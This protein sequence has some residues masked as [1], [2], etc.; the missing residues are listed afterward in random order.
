MSDIEDKFN[1][2]YPR[3]LSILIHSLRDNEEDFTKASLKIALPLLAIPMMIELSMEAIFAVVDITFVSF[4]GTDAVAAVGITEALITVVYAVCMGLGVTVTAMV[5]RRIGANKPKEAA[6][7]TGQIIWIAGVISIIV[8]LIGYSFAADLLK[9]L[10]ASSNVISIGTNYTAIVFGGSASIMYL[11]LLNA[12][13]RGAGDASIAFKALALSNAMNIILD[14]CLI[15][16]LGPFP[17]LGVT[18]AAIAT[19]IGRSFGVF[20]LAYKIFNANN[21]LRLSVNDLVINIQSIRKIL[22]TSIYGISQFLISTSSWLVL[23]KIIALFGTAPVA[24]Y[25]IAMRLME[26]V[27]LPVWGLGNAAATLVGQNMGANQPQRAIRSVQL[28]MRYGLIFMIVIGV[29][30]FIFAGQIISL[31][32]SDTEVIL[33]GINCLRII[34]IGYP[35]LA[36]GMI[37]VQSLNGAGD[38]K[39]PAIINFL[40]Y[41]VIQLPLAYW[42]ST[43]TSLELNGVFVAL[44]IAEVILTIMAFAVFK[45]GHWKRI[46]I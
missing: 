31:L 12:A 28:T 7:V 2:R 15:F 1:N 21:R 8:S 32:S 5:S 45:K 37:I 24:A 3:W 27:W 29:F 4:L 42:L 43:N 6:E 22:L 41:W 13:F 36:I 44:L 26:F 33:Y 25:T 38:I 20:Y 14:P 16:G 9:L 46:S 19:T 18:G 40:C 11:F 34:A 35:A 10:G 17:E 23:I 30:Q 39:S